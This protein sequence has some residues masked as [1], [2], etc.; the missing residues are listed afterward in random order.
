MTRARATQY[1][2]HQD[3]G[4]ICDSDACQKIGGE[5]PDAHN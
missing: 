2:V 5:G 3:G 1:P 4:V